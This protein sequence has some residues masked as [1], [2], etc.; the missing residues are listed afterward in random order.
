M[1][2]VCEVLGQPLE[3]VHV[4]REVLGD[5]RLENFENTVL[6]PPGVGISPRKANHRAHAGLGK[7]LRSDLD[8][9]P[10]DRPRSV[11][12]NNGADVLRPDIA[13]S[14]FQ[15]GQRLSQCW[16]QVLVARNDLAQFL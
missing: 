6:T 14:V 7:N 9:E 11:P 5:M 3:I 8:A 4:F 16:P 2:P 10:L 15:L 13:N 1:F 12:F